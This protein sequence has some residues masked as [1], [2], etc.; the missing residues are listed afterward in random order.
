M[1]D[2]MRTIVAR[3]Q[4]FSI[5]I[6][7]G[8]MRQWLDADIPQTL[9]EHIALQGLLQGQGIVEEIAETVEPAVADKKGKNTAVAE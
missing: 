8:G 1:S 2:K 3:G 5:L 4:G 7:D 6:P 9:P